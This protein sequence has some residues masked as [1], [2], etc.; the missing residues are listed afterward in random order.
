[1]K[2]YGNPKAKIIDLPAKMGLQPVNK[3]IKTIG[4]CPT[5]WILHTT[6]IDGP[7]IAHYLIKPADKND[8]R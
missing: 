2:T 6:W 7:L 3:L 1:M 4:L 8:I 5:Y